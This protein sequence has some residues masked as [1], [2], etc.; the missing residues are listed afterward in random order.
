MPE[1]PSL[2]R[3]LAGLQR[4][5]NADIVQLTFL[6]LG[7]DPDTA[8]YHAVTCDGE[9]Y[10]V[11]LKRGVF[12]EASVTLPG[13]LSDHGVA[14][15]I[16]PVPTRTGQLWTS[17]E[18]VAVTM[19]PFV[20]GK[21]GYALSLTEQN[22]RDLGIALKR[23]HTLEVPPPLLRHLRRETYD[24]GAREKV[25][26]FLRR[27]G[28][29][30]FGDP[31]ARRLAAFMHD[32]R[33][34]VLELVDRAESC[35]RVLRAHALE[36]MVCHADLHAG[37]LLISAEQFYIVDWDDPVLAPKERDLMFI[38]GGQGFAGRTPEEEE[39][40]FYQGY[41]RVQVDPVALVYY[42]C[43][44]IVQDIAVYCDELTRQTGSAEDREQ[45]LHY[46]MANFVPGGTL[47]RAYAIDTT[48][49]DS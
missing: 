49:A 10:F 39:Q 14:H 34:E 13:Y 31:V 26:E 46:L 27:L 32:K 12:D 43:E 33:A 18:D 20:M 9:P 40:L 47:E 25:T 29:A 37:N 45:S 19:Y 7:A 42:R 36:P 22:W 44:R 16:T 30:E 15:I 11:K 6:P 23:L 17:L 41:G 8:V 35:T 21:S 5:Y 1:N 28:D 48:P 3:L 4:A 38:G 2:Q 24:A